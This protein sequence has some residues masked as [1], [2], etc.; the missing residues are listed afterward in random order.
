MFRFFFKV[1]H[2]NFYLC[3][4]NSGRDYEDLE[5]FKQDSPVFCCSCGLILTLANVYFRLSIFVHS[6]SL[7]FQS[8]L[9][10]F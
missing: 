10:L 1:W 5:V 4:F 3:I 9:Q 2:L 7:F 8:F 6:D